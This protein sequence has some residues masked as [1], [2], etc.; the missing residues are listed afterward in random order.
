MRRF[1][2][3]LFLFSG[4]SVGVSGSNLRI[5]S[6]PVVAGIQ[7][8]MVLLEMT[9]SWDNS[10]YN[11]YNFDAVYLFGK[12]KANDESAWQHI[13]PSPSGH[14][15]VTEGYVIIE[16]AA[17]LFVAPDRDVSGGSSVA[18]LRFGWQ[19]PADRIARLQNGEFLIHF[20]GIEMVYVPTSPFSAG[21]AASRNTFSSASLGILPAASDLIGAN[22]SYAYTASGGTAVAAA[23]DRKDNSLNTSN[24][25]YGAETPSWWQV[26]FKTKKTI[27]YFGVSSLWG[28]DAVPGGNWSLQGSSPDAP[29]WVTLW[30]GDGSEWSRSRISWPVQHA[31]RVASP[32]AYQYYRI[33]IPAVSPE[34]APF[35]KDVRIA[36]VA[37]TEEELYPEEPEGVLIDKNHLLPVTYPSG[38][39][40]FFTMK[41]EVTQEQYVSFLNKQSYTAQYTRTIGGT[42]DGVREGEYL[43]GT[44]RT[45]PSFRNG[46]VLQS[47][48]GEQNP[49]FQFSC[50][51]APDE[52]AGSADGGHTVACNYLSIRDLLAYADWTGLRPLS[53]LEYEKA[54]RS[55]WPF[56]GDGEYAWGE[57]AAEAGSGLTAAGTETER[58]S[59]GNVNALNALEGPVRSGSFFTSGLS[60]GRNGVSFWGVEDLSGNLA[61]IYY[62]TAALGLQLT[63]SVHG[64]GS[65][66]EIGDGNVDAQFWPREVAA[67]GVRGGSFDSEETADIRLSDR[68]G[69]EGYFTDP[70]ERRAEVGFRLGYSGAQETIPAEIALE[71]GLVSKGTIV[72]DTVC[73]NSAYTLTGVVFGKEEEPCVYTWYTS[74]DNV[75]WAGLKQEVRKNLI[76]SDLTENMP[77]N[78]RRTVYY[79]RVVSFPDGYG[80]SGTVGLVVVRGGVSLSRLADSL[81]PCMVAPGFTVTTLLPARFEWTCLDNGRTLTPTSVTSVST[82]Y[83]LQT[84][85]FKSEEEDFPSGRYTIRVKMTVAERCEFYR[86]LEVYA[87]PYTKNPFVAEQESFTYTGDTW[88]VTNLWGGP[89]QQTWT[90]VNKEKGTLA[91]GATGRISGLSGTMCSE[92]TVSAVCAA[93]PDRIYTKVVS[94][95]ARTYSYAGARQSL[96]LL[97]GSYKM[98]CWGA[99]GGGTTSQ[100]TGSHAG[101]GGY[102]TGILD[103]AAQRNFF[104]YVGGVGSG[105]TGGWNGG[106]NGYSGGYGGGGATDIRLTDGAWNLAGSL[107]SRIMVGGGG[108]GGDDNLNEVVGTGHDGSGGGGGGLTGG[109][110]R[111]DGVV[112]NRSFYVASAT[113][114]GGCG[115]GG[116]QTNGYAF[117]QGEH[118]TYGTDTGGAGGGYRGGYVSNHNNGGGGG[119]SGFVSGMSGCNAVN[120]SGVNTNSAAHYSGLIFRSAS[121]STNTR[122][123]HGAITIT[124]Q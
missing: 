33:Y 19:L 88:Q 51:L 84:N 26:D 73:A 116:T 24:S 79:K 123:G 70:N 8:N 11:R 5:T 72:Y 108:G 41:Y 83:D 101:L 29:A 89:D 92:V 56:W 76:L 6:Q 32:G 57:A 59:S 117:G 104:L 44:D 4:I 50:R 30:E 113:N 16:A 14:R 3:F 39:R 111:I 82:H 103:L 64:D 52:L 100:S 85:D 35:Y 60:F 17:G 15:A 10:W 112:L 18:T 53:E 122:A 31:I 120:T 23:A 97:P 9:V 77:E 107:Y 55:P 34:R 90:I 118:V 65:L 99:S 27:R 87:L 49:A 38:Y 37:M 93:A 54:G 91:I 20:E 69:M 96:Y 61:E 109:A 36:N 94:E 40:G 119:G 105:T 114:G 2:W 110:A 67:F 13:V 1:I 71:N 115:M 124:V 48:P 98:E 7:G 75:H 74:T 68:H 22:S 43:F 28:T 25:W 21:D 66:D 45:A 62:N 78:S 12:Y 121:M 81:M 58:F 47:K 102:A 86:N 106:G 63:A 95:R 42:L 80:E 46:I